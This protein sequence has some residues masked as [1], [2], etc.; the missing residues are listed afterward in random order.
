M[1]NLY[2]PEDIYT[3]S[4]YDYNIKGF[5]FRQKRNEVKYMPSF[6]A[7]AS[8]WLKQNSSGSIDCNL[9]FLTLGDID[10]KNLTSEN[11]QECLSSLYDNAN[12]RGRRLSSY[13]KFIGDIC[14]FAFSLGYIC[15]IPSIV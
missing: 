7:V 11:I 13:E 4:K 10:I 5:I 1:A 14:Q 3:L 2:Q 15:D 9:V 6:R 8:D 12:I